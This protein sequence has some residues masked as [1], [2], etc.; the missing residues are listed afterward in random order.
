MMPF[1]IEKKINMNILGKKGRKENLRFMKI[2][3]NYNLRTG[4]LTSRKQ[5]DGKKE[6]G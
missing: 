1:V 3:K 6:R 4:Y 2:E 5:N